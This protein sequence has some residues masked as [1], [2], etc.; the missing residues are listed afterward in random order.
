MPQSLSLVIVHFVWSTKERYPFINE[1]SRKRLHGYLATLCQDLD[2][3]C[4]E[5]DGTT[6]ASPQANLSQAVGLESR[7]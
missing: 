2:C 1:E 6:G 4:F 5:I 7:F 3:H